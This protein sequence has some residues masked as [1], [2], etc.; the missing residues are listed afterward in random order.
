MR[1]LG[2]Q[3]ELGLEHLVS[4]KLFQRIVATINNFTIEMEYLKV[5]IMVE[6][7]ETGPFLEYM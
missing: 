2:K 1:K 3:V 5:T 7:G 4:Y 6:G